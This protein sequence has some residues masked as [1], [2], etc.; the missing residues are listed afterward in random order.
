MRFI[1]HCNRFFSYA[2]HLYRLTYLPSSDHFRVD[3]I[4]IPNLFP[5]LPLFWS[6]HPPSAIRHS[7]SAIRHPPSQSCF[8]FKTKNFSWMTVTLLSGCSWG[9]YDTHALLL[10]KTPTSPLLPGSLTTYLPPRRKPGQQS[11]FV[12]SFTQHYFFFLYLVYRTS[13]HSYLRF[14]TKRVRVKQ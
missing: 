7:P 14:W 8:A 9:C 4:F 2:H 13:M 12:K 6:N 5:S 1:I 11:A 3:L 10:H